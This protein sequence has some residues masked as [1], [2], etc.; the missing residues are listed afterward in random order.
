MICA[1]AVNKILEAEA[2]ELQG[3]GGGPLAE[4]IR[5][6]AHCRA[7][8]EA[9]LDGQHRLGTELARAVEPPDLDSLLERLGEGGNK[10]APRLPPGPLGLGGKC[11]APSGGGDGPS[12]HWLQPQ[13]WLPFFSVVNLNFPGTPTP[14]PKGAPGWV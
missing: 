3:L 5:G 9:V 6:C 12:Y 1:E 8:A 7:A 14:R 4:H 13:L 2:A 10:R 11:P